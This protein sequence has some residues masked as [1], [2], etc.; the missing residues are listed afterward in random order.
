MDLLSYLGQLARRKDTLMERAR[1]LLSEH[2]TIEGMEEEMTKRS[3]ALVDRLRANRIRFSEFQRIA[4]DETVTGSAAG[5]MLGLKSKELN[6][7]RWAEV[8]KILVYIL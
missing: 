2:K 8:T 3:K 5:L 4:A 7:I 1:D 6:S